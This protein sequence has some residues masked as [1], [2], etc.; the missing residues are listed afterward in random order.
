MPVSHA[1]DVVD[2]SDDVEPAQVVGAVDFDNLR[3]D[4]RILIQSSGLP[5]AARIY[6]PNPA[7]RAEAR[8][9]LVLSIFR[10]G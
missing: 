2:L 7:V 9:R 4:L 6:D 5:G 3:E 10:R 1:M 8:E